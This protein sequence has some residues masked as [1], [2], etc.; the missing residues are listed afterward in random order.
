M[1]LVRHGFVLPLVCRLVHPGS[2]TSDVGQGGTSK[3][4]SNAEYQRLVDRFGR[5]PW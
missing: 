2:G 4:E 1:Q 3:A 5:I